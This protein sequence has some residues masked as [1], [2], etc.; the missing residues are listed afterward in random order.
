MGWVELKGSLT[1]LVVERDHPGLMGV[2]RRVGASGMGDILDSSLMSEA[3][4]PDGSGTGLASST[5]GFT[6]QDTGQDDAGET[7]T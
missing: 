6:L 4:A 7:Q 2:L 3:E 5:K 1:I